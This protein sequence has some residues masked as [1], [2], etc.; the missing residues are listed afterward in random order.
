MN[1]KYKKIK[2]KQ[3]KETIRLLRKVTHEGIG[4]AVVWDFLE[5]YRVWPKKK[6]LKG[7]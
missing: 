5:A 2:N 1:P 7:A 4:N 3:L 6:R